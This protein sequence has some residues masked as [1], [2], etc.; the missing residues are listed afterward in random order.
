MV[1]IYWVKDESI[2]QSIEFDKSI[3][4][5][6]DYPSL[7]GEIVEAIQSNQ[8]LNILV[9]NSLVAKWIEILASRYGGELIDLA[10]S[11]ENSISSPP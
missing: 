3:C 1:K 5:V 9:V 2:I 8:D 11:L 10:D 7:Y 4:A 6:E